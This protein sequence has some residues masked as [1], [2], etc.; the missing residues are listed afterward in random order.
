MLFIQVLIIGFALFSVVAAVSRHQRGHVG[1]RW[2]AFWILFWFAVG[3]VALVPEA[4]TTVAG[5]FGV[6][7]GVDFLFYLGFLALFYL[8]FRLFVRLEGLEQEI[9][10]LVRELALARTE[11]GERGG[12]SAPR[13]G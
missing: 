6:G 11:D 4:T 3:G 12:G 7:R 9:T 1:R 5:W 10:R 13:E 8:M 2:L